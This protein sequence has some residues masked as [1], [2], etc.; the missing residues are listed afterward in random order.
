MLDQDARQAVARLARELLSLKPF[1]NALEPPVPVALM[2]DNTAVQPSAEFNDEDHTRLEQLLN[3][4]AAGVGAPQLKACS[5]A[6]S[7][8]IFEEV[9]SKRLAIGEYYES[10]SRIPASALPDIREVVEE[11]IKDS[12]DRKFSCSKVVSFDGTVLRAY[13]GGAQNQK[14]VVLVSGCGMPAKL[15][16]RWMDFLGKDH[17]IITWETRGL[18]EETKNFDALAFD[19]IAQ[20]KDLFAVMDHFGVEVAHLMGHCGGAVIALLAASSRPARVSSMSLWHGDLELG[21][22]CPRTKHQHHLKPLMLM[23]AEGRPHAASIHKLVGRALLANTR[24]DMAHIVLY[25][26]VNAELLF[27]YG[28]LNGCI[29]DTDISYVFSKVFHPTLVVTSE[30]DDTAHPAGSKITAEKLP[31]AI[32]H[33]E[34]HGDHMSLFDAQPKITELAARFISGEMLPG[35][36]SVASE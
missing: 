36:A 10:V 4:V 3:V 30:E 9:V 2:A 17:F 5:T 23:A 31:N 34:P 6:A 14:V 20:A 18:F 13:A 19:V 26:Y 33:V 16:E 35:V 32:L 28:R 25:P 15:C 7:L 21:P 24:A 11:V 29:M 22:D 27:R 8:T 1:I 12:F